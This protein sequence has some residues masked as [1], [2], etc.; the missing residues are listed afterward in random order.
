MRT[1]VILYGLKSK[2]T[3]RLFFFGFITLGIYDVYYI[4]LQTNILNRHLRRE[5]RLSKTFIN[6]IFAVN[7]IAAA[8]L[9][10]SFLDRGEEFRQIKLLSSI[11][12]QAWWILVTI[13]TFLARSRMNLLLSAKRRKVLWFHGAWTFLFSFFYFNFKINK[14]NKTLFHRPY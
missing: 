7:A 9:L 4:A 11:L 6:L 14:L 12:Y 8:L 13:W 10:A 3:W 5:E 2:S 1:D